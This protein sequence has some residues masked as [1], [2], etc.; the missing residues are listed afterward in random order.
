[1]LLLDEPTAGL[2]LPAREAVL[3]TLS[4]LHREATADAAREGGRGGIAPA[5][6]TVTH[7]LEEL[8]PQTSNVLLLSRAGEVVATG[9]T[10][11]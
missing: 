10:G 11:R 7:H 6:V 1:M 9:L 4:R 5:I 8:L 3:A 2:D